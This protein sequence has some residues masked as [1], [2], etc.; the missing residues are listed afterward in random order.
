MAERNERRER[1]YQYR[2]GH[3]PVHRMGAVWKLLAAGLLGG[4]ALAVHSLAGLLA[5]GTALAAGYAWAGLGL[6]LLWKDLRWLLLQGALIVV[7]TLIV[8]GRDAFGAGLRTAM[9]LTL[10]FLPAALMLRTTSTTSLQA[11]L[12]RWLPER[13]AFAAGATLRFVPVFTR[14]LGELVEMQRLRG[15]R[16]HARD[17]WRPGAWSDWL[18]CIAFPM[19]VRSVEVAQQAAEAAEMRGV[20]HDASTPMHLRMHTLHSDGEPLR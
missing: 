15:A 8:A 20:G 6:R 14:E 16:L 2:H 10:V 5:L 12:Q 11:P 9:Q 4:L 17:L 3:S 18:H 13:L 7:L 1:A 19:T